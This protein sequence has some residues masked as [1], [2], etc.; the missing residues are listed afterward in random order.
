MNA[1]KLLLFMHVLISFSVSLHS[2]LLS[3]QTA[4]TRLGVDSFIHSLFT[5]K[6]TTSYLAH[7][8]TTLLLFCFFPHNTFI[9]PIS[10]Q[11]LLL[12]TI[13]RSIYIYILSHLSFATIYIYLSR[14]RSVSP[15]SFRHESSKLW[16]IGTN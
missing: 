11:F 6:I 13:T 4:A 1:A 7:S 2:A 10:P 5:S 15:F 16:Y 12:S 8:F 14:T 3:A 9:L